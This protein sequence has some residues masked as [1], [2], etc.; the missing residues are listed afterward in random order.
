[1]GFSDEIGFPD[2]SAGCPI[3][4]FRRELRNLSIT[5]DVCDTATTFAGS[6]TDSPYDWQ[7][8]L[9]QW[10]DTSTAVALTLPQLL[11]RAASGAEPLPHLRLLA[12]AGAPCPAKLTGIWSAGRSF[13]S[14]YGWAAAGLCATMSR[15]LSPVAPHAA[16]SI[17]EPVAGA[18]CYVLDEGMNPQPPGVV[19]EI[20][21][22]GA[23]LARGYHHRPGLTGIRLIADPYGAPGDRMYR[24]GELGCGRGD[25]ELD[26]H[27]R[28]GSL[29]SDSSSATA[30]PPC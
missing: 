20:Y 22:A 4:S 14:G 23:G 21:V 8:Q 26:H 12:T 6:F 27:G 25:G 2:E 30:P 5:S 9:R 19:G 10:N 15:P 13:V 29:R 3:P 16:V 24:T 17:G 11:T 28:L 1:M 18:R 7:R